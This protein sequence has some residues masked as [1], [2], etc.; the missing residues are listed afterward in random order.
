LRER[1]FPLYGL[2]QEPGR[3]DGMVERSGVEMPREGDEI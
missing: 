3:R 1:T 2:M